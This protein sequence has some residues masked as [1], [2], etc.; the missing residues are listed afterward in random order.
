MVLTGERFASIV[1]CAII[2]S[3][4]CFILRF[5]VFVCYVLQG[6]ADIVDML[7]GAGCN[8]DAADKVSVFLLINCIAVFFQKF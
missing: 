8:L 4:F 1:S 7:I 5:V 6:H 3:S 2:D